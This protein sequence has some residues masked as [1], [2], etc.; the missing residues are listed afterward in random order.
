MAHL[1]TIADFRA[2]PVLFFPLLDISHFDELSRTATTKLG[3]QHCNPD[4][5]QENRS[6]AER[7]IS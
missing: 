7:P 2:L 6:D 1:A 3:W 5:A 4:W